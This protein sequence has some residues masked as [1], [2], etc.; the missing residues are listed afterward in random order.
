MADKKTKKGVVLMG[1]TPFII[2]V[3]CKKSFCLRIHGEQE[4]VVVAGM[5]H[6][7]VDGVHRL[8]RIHVGNILTQNPHTVEG[9]L[10]LQQVV[11]TSR[12]SHEVDSREDALVAER[13]VELKLHVARSL[14]LLEDHL[15]HLAACIDE[16]SGDDGERAAS[17]DVAGSSEET[18]RFLQ[19]IGV[20]TTSKNLA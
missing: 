10:V 14:E 3:I 12:R 2:I 17:L 1:T 13:A 15:V 8:H 20:D 11:A 16:G 7:L 4:L 6:A 19:G 9:G 18:L 5:L